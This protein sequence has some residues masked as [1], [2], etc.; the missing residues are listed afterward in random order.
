MPLDSLQIATSGLTVRAFYFNATP[1]GAAEGQV[2]TGAAFEAWQDAHYAAY[3]QAAAEAG[4]SAR[5]VA[6]PPAHVVAAGAYAVVFRKYSGA[7][8]SDVVL[9]TGGLSQSAT[10]GVASGGLLSSFQ[11]LTPAS[12]LPSVGSVL[13]PVTVA[14]GIA[15]LVPSATAAALDGQSISLAINYPVTQQFTISGVDATNWT[16]IVLTIKAKPS[17]ADSAALIAVKVSNPANGAD[18]LIVLNGAAPASPTSNADGT[19]SV[20][21]ASATELDVT[22]NLTARGSAIAEGIDSGEVTI[23]KSAGKAPWLGTFQVVALPTLRQ[24]A[25]TS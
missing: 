10:M 2:S 22:L 23:Y 25:T 21:T 24:S 15:G 5:Y 3:A 20:T 12:S 17:D 19:L 9:G 18:G 11:T 14:G 8:A 16:E 4:T 7:L 6:T 1:G 13:N